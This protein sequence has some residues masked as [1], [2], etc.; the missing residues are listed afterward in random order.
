MT[1]FVDVRL[2]HDTSDVLLASRKLLANVGN[3]ERL[4]VVIFL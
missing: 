2:D 4:V 1:T 3:D